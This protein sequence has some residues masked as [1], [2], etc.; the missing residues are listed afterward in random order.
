MS[1]T[2]SQKLKVIATNQMRA[3]S[4]SSRIIMEAAELIEKNRLDCG[5]LDKDT[6][7]KFTYTTERYTNEYVN[8]EIVYVSPPTFLF[9]VKI[10]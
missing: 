10:D 8:S 7:K 1:A 4:T 6:F 3:K 5:E 9:D 2:L